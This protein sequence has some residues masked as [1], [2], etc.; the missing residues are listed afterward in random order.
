MLPQGLL[1]EY[2]YTLSLA[3]RAMD[4]AVIFVAGILLAWMK[5]ESFSIP[6]HYTTALLVGTLLTPVIFNFFAFYSSMRAISFIG[7]IFSLSQAVCMLALVLAGMAFFTK[8]GESYSRVWFSNWMSFSLLLLVLYR[9]TF[10]PLLRFMRRHGWNERRVVI[11]G[12]GELGTKFAGAV[13]Q[14]MWTGFRVT[15]FIDDNAAH[16]A[17]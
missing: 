14:A 5:F 9:C 10:L 4:M 7:H 8:S 13:Q 2:W 1:K 17:P 15:A 12:A 11:F 16:K 3:I 6:S